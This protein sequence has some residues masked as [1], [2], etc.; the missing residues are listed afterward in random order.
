[1]MEIRPET[2]GDIPG[3]R[4][5]VEAAFGRARSAGLVAGLRLSREY[6]ELPETLLLCVTELHS[7]ARIDQ[8]VAA[9]AG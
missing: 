3:I 4:R 6:P 7:P 2:A 5:A 8:L 9:L 1:M